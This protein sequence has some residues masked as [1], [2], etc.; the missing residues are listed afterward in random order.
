MANSLSFNGNNLA[1]YGAYLLKDFIVPSIPTP[2][3][4]TSEVVGRHGGY[5]LNSKYQIR[6]VAVPMILKDY[7]DTAAFYTAID[8]LNTILDIRLGEKQLIFDYNPTRYLM[9]I[10][11]GNF[12]AKK[13]SLTAAD[14]KITFKCVDPFWYS[15]TEVTSPTVLIISPQIISLTPGG[16]MDID[17][18]ITIT[19]NAFISMGT[20][21]KVSNITANRNL[22]WVTPSNLS[23]DDEITIDCTTWLVKYNGLV[24]MATLDHGSVFPVLVPA[25][26]NLI[27]VTGVPDGSIS[28]VYRNRYL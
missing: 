19:T 1:T 15:T 5:L 7:A 4:S 11:S 13:L 22:T 18:V 28:I 25:V 6:D 9:A 17:P 10:A 3:L 16:N 23:A 12:D 20:E 14:A 2:K 21:I 8:N 24:S 26:A 27:R